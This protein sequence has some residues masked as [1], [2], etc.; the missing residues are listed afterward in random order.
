[1]CS[2]RCFTHISS[3]SVNYKRQIKCTVTC[4]IY[5]DIVFCNTKAIA[6]ILEEF[7]CASKLKT[8]V[9][10]MEKIIVQ[11]RI[12]LPSRIVSF[13][14]F[15]DDEIYLPA[16]KD[17]IFNK[18]IKINKSI[19]SCCCSSQRFEIQMRQKGSCRIVLT[20]V[21]TLLPCSHPF[22]TKEYINAGLTVM[23]VSAAI[24]GGRPMGNPRAW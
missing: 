8:I 22:L 17:Y 1:M 9:L 13:S 19:N 20:D 11:I 12:H 18:L 24:P 3:F 10:S 16:G 23:R 4:N 6:C 7:H 14:S 15:P 2:W 21:L 5:I